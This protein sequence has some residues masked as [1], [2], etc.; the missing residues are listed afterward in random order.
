MAGQWCTSVS[1]GGI[2]DLLEVVAPGAH[3]RSSSRHDQKLQPSLLPGFLIESPSDTRPTTS[4]PR[5]FAMSAPPPATWKPAWH[6]RLGPVSWVRNALRSRV[7][8][9]LQSIAATD[10]GRSLAAQTLRGQLQTS[11][12]LPPESYTD[13]KTPYEELGHSGFA[14]PTPQQ[15][16]PIFIT[17]RFRS[18]STL[19]WNLFRQAR[20]VT[21]YY[22]PLNERRFRSRG[23]RRA[24]RQDAPPG[25][26]LLAR[27]RRSR[28]TR[29][30][31]P[32]GAR[33]HPVSG[34]TR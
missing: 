25:F 6:Q 9:Y 24:H 17:G 29:T 16:P 34:L 22:E 14:P 30:V 7:F 3:R 33:M 10:D 21:S 15:G 27:A 8:R 2:I 19:L 31:L 32:S 12:D 28:R 13:F 23:A 1:R 26:G 18:G 20:G 11:I 4:S 5:N